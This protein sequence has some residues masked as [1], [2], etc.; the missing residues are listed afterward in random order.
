[1]KNR[2]L[3]VKYLGMVGAVLSGIALV[4]AGSVVEGVGLI[5]AAMTSP[6]GILGDGNVQ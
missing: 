6:T 3:F 4:V 2:V 5:A 1:M